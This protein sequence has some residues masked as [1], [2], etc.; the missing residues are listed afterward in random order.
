MKPF[1]F[2]WTKYITFAFEK[3]VKYQR[4]DTVRCKSDL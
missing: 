1:F 4:Y 2:Y 3:L